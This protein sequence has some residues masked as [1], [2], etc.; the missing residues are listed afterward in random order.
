MGDGNLELNTSLEIDVRLKE[1]RQGSNREREFVG[2]FIDEFVGENFVEERFPDIPLSTQHRTARNQ[3][4]DFCSIY[5]ISVFMEFLSTDDAEIMLMAYGFLDGFV[6]KLG[7]RRKKYYE[8]AHSYNKRLEKKNRKDKDNLLREKENHII[9]ALSNTLIGIK[10]EPEKIQKFTKE[11]Y[12]NFCHNKI[13]KKIPPPVA[14]YIK[15]SPFSKKGF[16]EIK[17]NE[18]GV[19]HYRVIT[20]KVSICGKIIYSHKKK[21]SID[22]DM[23]EYD[24]EIFDIS[25]E[26]IMAVLASIICLALFVSANKVWQ[27]YNFLNTPTADGYTTEPLRNDTP[28]EGQKKQ[29]WISKAVPYYGDINQDSVSEHVRPQIRSV[30]YITQSFWHDTDLSLK[31]PENRNEVDIASL[32]EDE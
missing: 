4:D 2:K 15:D 26:H 6:E 16:T 10:N 14:D 30:N 1:I 13:P 12:E 7:E 29:N 9:K 31:H 3:Y 24:E 23:D 27:D 21:I 18:I 20:F 22:G 32:G 11:V 25:K 28:E 19:Q 5:L 17:I 8:Y